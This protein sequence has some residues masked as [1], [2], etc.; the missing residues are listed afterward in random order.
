[1][2]WKYLFTHRYH[3]LVPERNLPLEY[4]GVSAVLAVAWLVTLSQV[5]AR[6]G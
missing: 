5:L 6:L 2:K 4:A 3:R 1:M